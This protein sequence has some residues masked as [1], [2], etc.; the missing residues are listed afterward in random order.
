MDIKHHY[1]SNTGGSMHSR[2]INGALGRGCD[3]LITDAPHRIAENMETTIN[4][5]RQGLCTRLN[6]PTTGRILVLMPCCQVWKPSS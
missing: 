6:T 1:V 5:V 2:F 3:Y 4:Y